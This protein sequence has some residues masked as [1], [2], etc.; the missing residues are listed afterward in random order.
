M[1]INQIKKTAC[2]ILEWRKVPGCKE[3]KIL[4]S[5]TM[6][7]YTWM[8]DYYLNLPLK[9]TDIR[10]SKRNKGVLKLKL[11]GTK[12]TTYHEVMTK[13]DKE[14]N[15]NTPFRDGSHI[16]WDGEKL[17]LPMY[18]ISEGKVMEIKKEKQLTSTSD[19]L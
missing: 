8:C 12:V 11:G 6:H 16:Q 3:V 17:N 2:L 13:I 7:Q 5:E 9:D 1:N 10:V 18:V 19:S 4:P 15:I 14:G